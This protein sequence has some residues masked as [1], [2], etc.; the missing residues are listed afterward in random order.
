MPDP[1]IEPSHYATLD[2]GADASAAALRQAYRRAAQR[3]HPDRSG[4]DSGA[5]ARMAGINEAY[6]VLS[7]PQR[8]A[9][10]DQWL[11]A[12]Q[13]RQHADAAAHAA[14]PSRFAATWPW[15]LVAATTAFAVFSVGAVVYKTSW[16]ASAIAAKA[17]APQVAGGR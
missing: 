11:R 4:G 2:V 3:H 13:A 6:A 16:A 7:H 8:R 9:S 1:S 14:R 10:Y 5:Q 17:A 15:G 12:R